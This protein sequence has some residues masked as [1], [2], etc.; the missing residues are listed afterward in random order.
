MPYPSSTLL[1]F[2]VS[3]AAV[4]KA[5]AQA[6]T[7]TE[8]T[9]GALGAVSVVCDPSGADRQLYLEV[10]FDAFVGLSAPLLE[11]LDVP[12]GCPPFDHVLLAFEPAGHPAWD[13]KDGG[14]GVPHADV[15]FF[16]IPPE[17]RVALTG[18]CQTYPGAPNCD[19]AAAANA[20]FFN[21]PPAD[22]TSGFFEDLTF[23]GHAVPLH[24]LHLLP[25]ADAAGPVACTSTGPK[26]DWVDCQNQQL[27]VFG[28]D[29]VDSGCTCS[30]W[31]DGVS[32]ILNVFD[33][34]VVGNEI[35]PSLAHAAALG[36]SLANPYL[37]A[38]P[39]AA[40]YEQPGYQPVQTRSF[41]TK[42]GLLQFGLVLDSKFTEGCPTTCATSRRALLFGATGECAAC[43]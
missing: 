26:G 43:P 5:A 15:H 28:G 18:E 32:A 19:Y 40:K 35:M 42:D 39:A 11:T 14:Y 7:R 6:A 8:A 22:Y 30:A 29:F 20:A 34:H 3:C 25:D 16:M 12:P 31:A 4:A 24:G 27:S 21:K 37:E 33:G 1:R 2:V 9:L 10:D 13:G 23:G 36:D 41:K 38:Y 17:V